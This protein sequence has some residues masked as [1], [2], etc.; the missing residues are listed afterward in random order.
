MFLFSLN[1][2]TF[3]VIFQTTNPTVFF[4]PLLLSYY[5]LIPLS[6]GFGIKS[7]WLYFLTFHKFDH[8][9]ATI[10]FLVHCNSLLPR[11][12]LFILPSNNFFSWS[13]ANVRFEVF[14][15]YHST[16]Q[17]SYS[18]FQSPTHYLIVSHLVFTVTR[19]II[20]IS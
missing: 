3:H 11:F 15:L 5:L 18:G 1:G 4:T 8:I 6:I 17:N 12:F 20:P 13:S 7:Y 14:W 9:P 2:A 16:V 10:F 19:T